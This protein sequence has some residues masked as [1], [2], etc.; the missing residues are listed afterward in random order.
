MW[1]FRT[2]QNCVAVEKVSLVLSVYDSSKPS[3]CVIGINFSFL[4][5]AHAISLFGAKHQKITAEAG[6]PFSSLFGCKSESL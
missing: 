1:F 3:N 2:N 6:P 4:F 5:V